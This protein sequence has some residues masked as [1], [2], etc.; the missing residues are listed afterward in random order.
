MS[1]VKTGKKI[2]KS[3]ANTMD[4]SKMGVAL[5]SNDAEVEAQAH[6]ALVQCPHCASVVRIVQ[7]DSVYAW[8]TCGCCGGAFYS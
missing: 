6:P 7:Y 4:R 3:E 5:A 8:Y 1:E 2:E